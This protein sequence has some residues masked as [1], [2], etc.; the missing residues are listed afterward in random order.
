MLAQLKDGLRLEMGG[1]RVRPGLGGKVDLGVDKGVE[2]E[3]K[4]GGVR[5]MDTGAREGGWTMMMTTMIMSR[6][7]EER[8]G[9]EG[10]VERA[11]DLN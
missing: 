7:S 6:K 10:F 5:G 3:G 11:L 8:E 9:A 4:R 2:R 1:I